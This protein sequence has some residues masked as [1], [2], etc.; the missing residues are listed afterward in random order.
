MRVVL[1]GASGLI[2]TA[3]QPVLREDGH[4]VDFVLAEHTAGQRVTVT[5]RSA[6]T[7]ATRTLTVE[8]GDLAHS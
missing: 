8:L 5:V 2:G 1:A 3:L 7:A 4:D 6:T